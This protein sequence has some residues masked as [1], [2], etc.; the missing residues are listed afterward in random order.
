MNMDHTDNFDENG[1]W[2]HSSLTKKAKMENSEI[3]AET[4]IRTLEDLLEAYERLS[5][6]LP[7]PFEHTMAIK[8]SAAR[9]IKILK[10]QHEN[11]TNL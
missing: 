2:T 9:V 4:I 1:T 3:N 8:E 11:S 7:F 5:C 10:E 6:G